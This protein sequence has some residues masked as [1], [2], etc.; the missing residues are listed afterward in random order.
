MVIWGCNITHSGSADGM[1]GGMIERALKKAGQVIVID[2]RRT[3]P[4]KDATHWLQIRPGT[5][6]ALALAMIHVIITENLIDND[7][8]HQ[9][10]VGYE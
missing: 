6:G 1:C 2:P 7:F 9:Y 8:V 5:D 10:T 4:A 3:R